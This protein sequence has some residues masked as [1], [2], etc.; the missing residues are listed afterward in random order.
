MSRRIPAP[1]LA[2]SALLAGCSDT[3]LSYKQEDKEVID[4]GS[5][6][7]RV[8]D[9][10]GRTWLADA[11]TYVN[12][13]DDAGLIYDTRKA[14]S[15]IDGYWVLD[16]L[17]GEEQYTVYVTSGVDVLQQEDVYVGSG[18]SITLEEPNC[19]DPLALKVAVVTGNYD[20]F[21]RVLDDMGF[22][23][24]ELVDG[25]DE[26]VLT[27]FLTSIDEMSKFDIIFFNG[28]FT[29]AGIIYDQEDE[30]NTVPAT[31]QDNL[32]T[33]V[34]A[35]G[36]TYWSDWAYDGVEQTWPD[37]I[38]FVGADEVPDDAQKGDYASLNATVADASLAEFLG[39][40]SITIEYDLPVWPPME[41]VS[42][43]V[44]VHLTGTVPYSDGLSDYTLSGVPLLVSFNDG[45]GKVVFSSFRVVR[46]GGTDMINTL[47][48]MMYNL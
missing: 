27:D 33:Y 44:S 14:Y 45:G 18:E 2:L 41:S 20:D 30:T 23:N 6:S 36:S 9:P 4:P 15:D 25:A 28:G 35:G 1:V 22:A 10:T 34:E 12:L 38:E 19:F 17:P 21:D 8:C 3:G 46:N 43:S 40:S 39:K 13:V 31:V 48:Y 5:I 47:Q 16:N 37:R 29:E 32:R 7:G 24:Y 11:L 42:A 26:A